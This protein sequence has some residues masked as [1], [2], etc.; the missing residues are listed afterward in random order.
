[1]SDKKNVVAAGAFQNYIN[2]AADTNV[3]EAIKKNTK[4]FKKLLKNIPQKKRNYAYAEGKWTIKELLQHM[5]DAERVFAYRALTFARLDPT[6]LA[7]FDENNWAIAANKINRKWDDLVKEFKTVRA[8][9]EQLFESL[10]E[11]ELLFTGTASNQPLNA[12]AMG[13]VIAGH[14]KHHADLINERYLGNK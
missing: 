11:P 14:V 6:P 13:Y 10:G 7:G 3:V 8:A 5:I 1:M 12:L 9:S 2:K 4:A